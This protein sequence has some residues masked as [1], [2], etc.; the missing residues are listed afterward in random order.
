MPST[1]SNGEVHRRLGRSRTEIKSIRMRIFSHDDTSAE[2]SRLE[3]VQPQARNGRIT[4]MR[5]WGGG[6]PRKHV[7]VQ[8]RK[9]MLN[10]F[11]S[12]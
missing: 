8:R 10:R 11:V 12:A 4:P 5:K 2:M 9:G 3:C 1:V 6:E 7:S